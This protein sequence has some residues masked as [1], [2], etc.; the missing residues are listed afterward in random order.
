M[1]LASSRLLTWLCG[2]LSLVASPNAR[3]A[4]ELPSSDSAQPIVVIADEANRWTQGQHDVWLLR[5]NCVIQHGTVTARSNSAVLWIKQ[6]PTETPERD[7]RTSGRALSELAAQP[8]RAIIYL[9][10]SVKIEN[11]RDGETY[12]LTDKTWLGE[13][14]SEFPVRVNIP[15]VGGEPDPKPDIFAR[16]MQR[17][18][19]RKA[20]NP[21]K[22]AQFQAQIQSSLPG[23]Q[24][25]GDLE[26]GFTRPPLGA[27]QPAPLVLPPASTPLDGGAPQTD[28]VPRGVRRLRA[29]PRSN[30]KV[31]A[32]W[33]TSPGGNESIAVIRSGVN[34]IIDGSPR[35]GS[36][37][38][39]ADRVVLWTSAQ[40]QPDLSGQSLQD[41]N[42]PLELY[43]EGNIEFREGDRIIYAERM[44]YD[45]QNEVATVLNAELLTPAPSFQGLIRLKADVVRQTGPGN[46]YARGAYF[47]TSRLSA[48]S[49]RLQARD[50]YFEDTQ[51]PQ[52]DPIT[53]S[54]IIDPATGDQVV[55]HQRRVS[56]VNNL[57]FLGPVPVFYWPVFSSNLEEST[58]YIRSVRY[59]K[60]SIFGNWIM[61]DLD[62]FQL[63]GMRSPPPGT[64]L[65]L[66]VDYL[67]KR[68]F[69]GGPT[70]RYNREGLFGI[71]GKYT[72]VLDG[73]LVHD[74]GFDNL[75]IG[76][77]GLVPE[78][79]LNNPSELMR[80]RAF[81][82]HRHFFGDGYQL[83]GELGYI[84]DRNFL[85]QYYEREW[86]QFKD[87]TTG[88]EFKRYINNRSWSI[89]TDAR[90]NP[91]FTQTRW[92]PRGDHFWIGQSLLGDHLT[93]YEH[94]QAGYA[95]E[96]VASTP[97]N[98]ADAA[99]FKLLPWETNAIGGR[100]ITRHEID[101][102][103]QLGVVKFTPYGLGEF[104]H[105][106]EAYN[107]NDL[108]RLYG[109]A[110]LRASVPFWSVNSQVENSLFNLH[111]LAHKVVLDADFSYADTNQHI[112]QLTLYEPVDDDSQE[113]FRRRFA[114]NTYG[115]TTPLQFDERFY[116]LRS[117]L[118]SWVTSPSAE[119]ADRLATLRTG[120][121][122]RWQTKRGPE[123]NR[124][125]IDWI[126]LD[127][128]AVYFPNPGRDNFGA[129]FGLV[130]Y[131]L[132]WH[133]GDRLT[134][135]S[136][137]GFDFFAAGQ[138]VL[139]VGAF[140][141]RPPRGTWYAGF[142]SLQ[143]PIKAEVLSFSNS[144][145]LSPKWMTTTGGSIDFGATGNI[146]QSFLI[147]RV[148]EA[149]LW[150]AGFTTD[151]GKQN[152]G[153][154]LMVQPRFAPTGSINLAGGL[155][156][157]VA[158]AYGLE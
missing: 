59:Q 18:L 110:G 61:V 15:R 45:A 139:T 113:H 151:Y 8:S 73:W 12:R 66:S 140:L 75:G 16:G 47:T 44:F 121:R 104:A 152:T 29:Y 9:E 86:D 155:P 129:P 89:T 117:G 142:R 74:E 84:S 105:W 19:P 82:Q 97:T 108:N 67:S 63:L 128:E 83:T 114:F 101:A 131:N 107:H 76:R 56:T 62:G 91:F 38:L 80:F 52:Y 57:L 1:H 33:L 40:N 94:S 60:D 153:L 17:R 148:G 23:P 25:A 4:V 141:N 26:P 126:T 27:T 20:E 132:N 69:A 98:P 158:G 31:Q 88:L 32:E 130:N 41:N 77:Q 133:V 149:L 99:T 112:D 143:G 127:M 157:P 64:D 72:G 48:P 92:L 6:L 106:D 123:N 21:V 54:P 103:F 122:Q 43:L 24:D 37:D 2:L 156:L 90:V 125:I 50:T 53:G 119:I 39:L 13:F 85:E 145:R 58:Y 111:G 36:V 93:W 42:T 109:Q 96:A 120:L 65:N 28:P 81:G 34:V 135:L 137:G 3:A 46:Y 146:G 100:Y 87:Q 51:I 7:E 55:D 70:F 71:P 95:Q 78:R 134:I 5:G 136:N 124:R 102:P 49:Y 118:G 68:G 116:A 150:S 115:G 10:G 14:H 147:T 22:P 79:R 30:A 35:A 11:E 154:T 138:Q 144:Y